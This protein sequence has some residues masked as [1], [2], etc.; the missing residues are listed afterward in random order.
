LAKKKSRVASQRRR[1]GNTSGRESLMETLIRR[2]LDSVES[3]KRVQVE[4][5]PAQARIRKGEIFFDDM[6]KYIKVDSHVVTHFRGDLIAGKVLRL[7]LVQGMFGP[8]WTVSISV[9]SHGGNGSVG[10]HSFNTVIGFYDGLREIPKLPIRLITAAEKATLTERGRIFQAVTQKST[11]MNYNA[12]LVVPSYFEWTAYSANG[13]VM[14]DGG[15]AR[16]MEPQLMDYG[17]GYILQ[18]EDHYHDEDTVIEKNINIP[19]DMLFMTWPMVPAFS[20][21]QKRWGLI[22]IKHLT[23]VHFDT[24]VFDKLV[25]DSEKK[26][27]IKSLVANSGTS[28]SDIVGG[29]SGGFIFLLHGAPGVGKTLTAEATAEVLSRPLYVVSVGEL[30]TN[31]EELEEALRKILELADRWNAVLLL[32]EADIFLEQ[33]TDHDLVRNAMVGIFLRL[34]EYFNGVL[35]LTTNRVKNFDKAFHSRISL[36]MK[37]D[38]ATDDV[39]AKIWN[40]LLDAA[41]VTG[42]DIPL[43][44]KLDLNGRQIKNCIRLASTLSK[45][46]NKQ[47]TTQDLIEMA[48]FSNDFTTALLNERNYA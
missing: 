35:F 44:A 48:K 14:I 7:E 31:P 11:F 41:G 28:F 45:N 19:D 38:K 37:Y 1:K 10:V 26:E 34:L 4:E 29:K 22:K 9:I 24:T 36:A 42:I 23:P 21:K 46:Q 15:G 8:Y 12:E 18:N 5:K 47:V 20:F 30:G 2:R 32:D 40:N 6:D 13:R 39:R 17:F 3:N 27:I 25:L 16:L 43:M 33:R